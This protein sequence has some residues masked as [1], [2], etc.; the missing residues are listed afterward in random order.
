MMTLASQTKVNALCGNGLVLDVGGWADPYPRADYVLDCFTYETRRLAYHGINRL[1]TTCRYPE[2]LA[3]ERFTKSTWVT[4]DIC[5][6]A[7]FPFPDKMFDFVICSHTLEDIRDPLRACAEIIRVGK[8]GYIETP[9]R[10]CEQTM[11]VE[12]VPG[13]VGYSHHRWLIETVGNRILFRPKQHFLHTDAAYYAPRRYLRRFGD[14]A[15]TCCFFWQDSFEYEE[16][17]ACDAKEEASQYVAN[18][19]IPRRDYRMD[20]RDDGARRLSAA[21]RNPVRGYYGFRRWLG[22][23]RRGQFRDM[24]CPGP[25]QTLWTWNELFDA[26][27]PRRTD[28][29]ACMEDGR[30]AKEDSSHS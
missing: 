28:G 26:G 13:M 7:P 18:L 6:P 1:P 21:L 4:H 23:V 3:G 22:R 25:S 2:P 9:S 30:K 17:W 27:T 10:L 8:A 24:S 16:L 12:G 14:P 20:R 15:M 11:G 19:G 29:N 5:G